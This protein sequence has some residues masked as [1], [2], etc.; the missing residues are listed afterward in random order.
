MAMRFTRDP[1]KDMKILS[2]KAASKITDPIKCSWR[3]RGRHSQLT[4]PTVSRILLHNARA[5]TASGRPVGSAQ[6]IAAINLLKNST[7]ENGC[8]TFSRG[9]NRLW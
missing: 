7:L 1:A 6:V 3:G 8:T 2:K 9:V 5:I 4:I